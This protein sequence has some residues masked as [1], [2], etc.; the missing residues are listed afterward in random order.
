MVG[1]CPILVVEGP[2][3]LEY[4][5]Q[6]LDE[7]GLSIVVI[8]IEEI[9][10]AGVCVTSA[11][12]RDQVIAAA[13]AYAE[14]EGVRFLADRDLLIGP[15]TD[16]PPSLLLTDFPALE[17][18]TLTEGTLRRLVVHARELP[19]LDLNAATRQRE[20]TQAIDRLLEALAAFLVP[21]YHLRRRHALEAAPTEFPENLRKFRAAGETPGLD[22][23][24]LIRHLGLSKDDEDPPPSI[25]VRSCA[26]LRPHAY[27]H[28]VARAVWAIWPRLRQ[29]AGIIGS[30]E[31]ERL[32]LSLVR[33]DELA[34]FGLFKS[35]SDLAS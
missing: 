25:A 22:T 13:S 16:P 7:L 21:L 28:D 24:K 8:S 26:E 31:L 23:E 14:A 20:Q 34:D 2:S 29:R 3:D 30:D 11:G 18:Y 5:Q 1:G 17:S 27:G 6:W 19:R 12:N 32:M 15:M 9:D 35:L 10:L 33:S 4:L